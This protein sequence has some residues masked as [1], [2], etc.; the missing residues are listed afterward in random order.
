MRPV[1]STSR[2][3]AQVRVRE[4]VGVCIVRSPA[5]RR[6]REHASPASWRP[7]MLC[8]RL[9]DARRHGHDHSAVGTDGTPW[10]PMA[11]AVIEARLLSLLH[12]TGGAGLLHRYAEQA[13]PLQRVAHAIPP[14][15]S[16]H[17]SHGGGEG[18]PLSL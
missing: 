7:V 13:V 6:A 3:P 12:S 10:L 17:F 4:S 15:P 1:A 11:D 8:W 2:M 9:Q 18:D 16:T 5:V 14:L